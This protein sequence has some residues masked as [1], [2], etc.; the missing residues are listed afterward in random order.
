[1][2]EQTTLRKWKIADIGTLL[3]NSVDAI[4]HGRFLMRLHVDEYFVHIVYVFFLMALLILFS[5]GIESSLNKV[6]ENK[7]KIDEL[8]IIYSDKTFEVANRSRRG[9]V[10][11]TLKAMG[12][13]IREPERP[14]TVI[15]R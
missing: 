13:D 11:E 14:A 12:S 15:K 4:I 3:K 9:A 2:K 10:E 8:E 7:K 1:M 5:L 6:E